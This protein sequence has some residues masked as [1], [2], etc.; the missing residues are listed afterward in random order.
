M[1]K[2]AFQLAAV[3]LGAATMPI[4]PAAAGPSQPLPAPSAPPLAVKPAPPAPP[5][6]AP[7]PLAMVPVPFPTPPPQPAPPPPVAP[8]PPDPYRCHPKED[9]ACTVVR[10]TARG[11]VIVTLRPSA[12]KSRPAAWSVVSGPPPGMPEAAGGTVYVV[13]TIQWLSE[14]RSSQR[15]VV[16]TANEAPIID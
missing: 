4:A 9:I 16:A 13:P 11:L 14:A 7:A 12:T 10:E 8:R 1:G 15:P 2:R 3:L 6:R 5:L